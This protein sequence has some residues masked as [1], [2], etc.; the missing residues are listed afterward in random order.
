MSKSPVWAAW[1]AGLVTGSTGI[2]LTATASAFAASMAAGAGAVEE[3][4]SGLDLQDDTVLAVLP[5]SRQNKT[6]SGQLL[7]QVADLIAQGIASDDVRYFGRADAVLA[8]A[9]RDAVTAR[10]ER[11][12]RLKARTRGLLHDFETS[13]NSLYEILQRQPG[14]DSARRELLFL[15]LLQ[16]DLNAAQ[17]HCRDTSG[18]RSAVSRQLCLI[19][20]QIARGQTVKPQ[21]SRLLEAIAGGG[22]GAPDAV[23][24]QDLLSEET[25]ARLAMTR[26]VSERTR[27][28]DE[29]RAF[30]RKNRSARGDQMPDKPR[31]AYLADRMIAA[32]DFPGVIETIPRYTRSFPLAV[33]L[34][35]A[36]RASRPAHNNAKLES[37]CREIIATE[38]SRGSIEHAREAAMF[39]LFVDKDPAQALRAA[40]ANWSRQKEWIDAWLLRKSGEDPVT[41]DAWKKSQGVVAIH[42]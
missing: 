11:F 41:L 35:V 7:D 20:L 29:L 39:A 25:F 3:N 17:G 18:F 14:N 28:R 32:G 9:G 21:S 12:L 1:V 8:A 13:R 16:G 34:A 6:S 26:D 33:R 40:R 27:L 42:D 24:A 5:P 30:A 2:F 31:M 23:W 36:L 19:H 4:D 38:S 10:S 37:F 15:D 22:A